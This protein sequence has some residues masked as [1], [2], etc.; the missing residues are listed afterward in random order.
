MALP[1][2]AMTLTK[3][4][5]DTGAPKRKAAASTGH[6]GERADSAQMAVRLIA[7]SRVL[8][9]KDAAVLSTVAASAHG[10]ALLNQLLAAALRLAI[11]AGGD[12][13]LSLTNIT[14]LFN[15][16]GST[17]MRQSAFEGLFGLPDRIS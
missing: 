4:R 12:A 15:V 6:F 10:A 16:T 5:I 17:L 1:C 11:A 8:L 14:T 3:L 7:L 9:T 13:T 2:L